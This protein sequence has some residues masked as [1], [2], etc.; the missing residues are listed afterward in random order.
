MDFSDGH[1]CLHSNCLRRLIE[2]YVGDHRQNF[3]VREGAYDPFQDDL[4]GRSIAGGWLEDDRV[5]EDSTAV[6][7][8]MR[9]SRLGGDREPDFRHLSMRSRVTPAGQT[10]LVRFP[11]VAK[12]RLAGVYNKMRKN[13]PDTSPLRR[14][15]TYCPR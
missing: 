12:S 1:H 10:T 5:S 11:R 13:K 9:R 8:P 4:L 15:L 7:G 3:S 6:L 14:E 2:R